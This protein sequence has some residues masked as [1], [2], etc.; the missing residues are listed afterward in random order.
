MKKEIQT[1][2]HFYFPQQLKRE[3]QKSPKHNTFKINRPRAQQDTWEQPHSWNKTWGEKGKLELSMEKVS[4]P[5]WD[6]NTKCPS[7]E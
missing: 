6:I 7:G 5:V 3:S 1:P 4:V 2:C